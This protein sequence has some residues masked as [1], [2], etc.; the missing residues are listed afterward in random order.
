MPAPPHSSIPIPLHNPFPASTPPV[1]LLLSRLLLPVHVIPP[2]VYRQLRVAQPSLMCFFFLL[3][4]VVSSFSPRIASHLPRCVFND[5][6]LFGPDGHCQPDL[7]PDR[8]GVQRG[9]NDGQSCPSRR[10]DDGGNFYGHSSSAPA[11]R[12]E[13]AHGGGH[14]VQDVRVETSTCM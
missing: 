1:S 7:D 11:T 5:S 9:Q 10:R 4:L 6:N 13:A 2:G 8:K 3:V 14:F 12:P